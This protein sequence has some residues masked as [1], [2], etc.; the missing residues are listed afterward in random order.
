MGDWRTLHLFDKTKYMEEVVPKIR[1]LEDYLPSFLNDRHLH[2]L[3][4]FS[5]P[6][7]QTMNETI[8]FVS[9]LN[10]ELRAHPVLTELK[11]VTNKNRD[12]YYLPL[13]QFTRQ[14]QTA[15][16]F[17]EYLVIETIFSTF[18]N[19]YPHFI[20][21]KRLFEHYIEAKANS[22]AEELSAKITTQEEDAVLDRIDGGIINWLSKEET[23]LLYMDRDHISPE[24]EEGLA[25]VAEFKEFLKI[26]VERNL[27]L[28]SLRN[29]SSDLDRFENGFPDILKA[30]EHSDFK[31]IVIRGN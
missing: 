17:F 16:E 22:I 13:E 2:W 19:F 28:I 21:G 14:R 9:E 25:Y 1:N 30:M 6:V 8:R 15:I 27:G 31:H 20:L 18:G 12:N 29:P 23:A 3:D 7:D 11:K 4:G 5:K 26:A 24:G 10:E